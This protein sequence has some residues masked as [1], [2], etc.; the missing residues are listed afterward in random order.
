MR[1]AL[2]AAATALLLTGCSTVRVDN[3]RIKAVEKIA[4]VSFVANH[5]VLPPAS[6]NAF[7]QS[8]LI[9]ATGAQVLAQ[10]I[11]VFMDSMRGTERF[12]LL[13]NEQV[14]GA[15]SYGQFPFLTATNASGAQLPAGGW[16]YV[17]PDDGEK[18]AN[19]LEEVDADGGLITWWSF[20]FDPM[21]NGDIGIALATSHVRLRAWLISRDGR[22]IFDDEIDV[23]SDESIPIYN[24]RYDA[25]AAPR[26][27]LS[28]M[29][30]AAIRLT[31]DLSNARA[32]ARG[33]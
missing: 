23:P 32:K 11:P 18:V 12:Q 8:E 16:R 7:A 26:L 13:S 5:W 30:T 31:A 29:N 3:S 1:R 22:K 9:S 20:T 25:G 28:P 33:E 15:K 10:G 21:M 17:T 27:F 19:L 2:A 6:D 24:G 4:L 14:L